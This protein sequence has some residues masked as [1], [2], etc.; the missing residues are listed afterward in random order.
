MLII[1]AAFLGGVLTIMS[2]C[3]LPVLPF[4]FARAG[5]PFMKSVLPMLVGMA[6]TF[7]IVAS[8][9]AV[10]GGWAVRVN[11]YGRVVALVFLGIFA[12]TLLSR[13]V[14]DRVTRPFV[15]LGNRMMEGDRGGANT[16]V[17]NSLMLGV[18]TGFLWV[19]CAGPILGIVLTGAAIS[20]PNTQTTLLLLAYA[21]GAATSLAVATLAGGRI[22]AAMKRSLGAGEWI[23]RG[24]GAAVL[25][26]VVAI[27]LG[28][29]SGIL[30]RLS[31][32]STNRFEQALLDK[33]GADIQPAGGAMTAGAM[34]GGAMTGGGA[35]TASGA[36]TGSNAMTGGARP[37]GLPVE[38]QLPPFNGA[39][40]WLNSA[41]LTPDSLRGKVVLIDFWTY[42]CI[43]CLRALPYINAWYDKYKDYGLVIVGVHS[44]EFAFEKNQGNVARAVDELGISYP[45]VLD[46]DYAIWK[47]FNN[48]YWP[49][50]Y[51]ADATGSIRAHHFGEG[52]YEE[53]EQIIRRLLT[54]AGVQNLPGE[55]AA[56]P[57]ASGVQAAADQDN[58]QSPE[59]YIG[60]E[61]GE[62]FTS[63]GG[64]VPDQ[65]HLYEAPA[66][67]GLNQWGLA[68]T[69][70][71]DREKATLTGDQGQVVFRFYA[72]DL[73]L[74]LG[75]GA[76]GK[77][78]RFRVLLDGMPPAASH[79]F[80]TDAEGNGVVQE[81]RLYQLIRQA[82]TVG[83]HT[84]TI[85]FLDS[86]V[87]AYSFTFG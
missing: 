71:V 77:P 16:G 40:A 50:H 70:T 24:L 32:E 64:I 5:Q 48:Q 45:V 43:N 30:T 17:A 65:A 62:N 84:F 54:E 14:A 53:S 51:F 66:N 19:P 72:R 41:P 47:A 3:I 52:S 87:Q 20:G 78:I 39:T 59:T 82:G 2:P 11:E 80:D 28:W 75:P 63:V 22:F 8:L 23:R 74:V 44:P 68:G 36:M 4:V 31:L 6:L 9:V 86:G 34:T 29:D 67:P 42:S 21:A 56:V 46:N 27:T 49:A 83:E 76:D 61:R 60:Y 12:L 55:E 13:T 26:A 10:G 58:L 85:E 7:A 33:L 81:E 18:A 1:L 69:W 79:G 57:G 73:H 15:A 37:T 25:L 35:M 38:G